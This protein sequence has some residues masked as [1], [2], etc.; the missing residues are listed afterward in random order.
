MRRYPRALA[1]WEPPCVGARSTR[2]LYSRSGSRGRVME[3][4]ALLR[5]GAGN[6]KRSFADLKNWAQ[7]CMADA[8]KASKVPLT[9]A[10]GLAIAW[11]LA[12]AG[13]QFADRKDRVM[14]SHNTPVWVQGDWVVGEYR[15]CDMPLGNT[16]LFCGKSPLNGSGVATFPESVSDGDLSAAVVA[17]YNRETQT[18]WSPLDRYFKVM[19]VRFYGRLQRP[20]H[21]RLMGTFSWRCQRNTKRL[22]CEP[23]E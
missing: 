1:G 15:N 2:K 10:V 12:V 13:Y 20:E 18:D 9:W 22:K 21:D 3:I 19:P 4:S 6:A 8:W 5:F 11:S 7:E 16:R 23:V 14:H 17:A